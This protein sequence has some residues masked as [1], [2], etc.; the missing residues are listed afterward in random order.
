MKLTLM[1]LINEV[2]ANVSKDP[3]THGIN[4]KNFN[5]F[6]VQRAFTFVESLATNIIWVITLVVTGEI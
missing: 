1:T 5:P 4:L 2:A 6:G 3:D